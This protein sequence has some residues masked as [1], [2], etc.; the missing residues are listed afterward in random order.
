MARQVNGQLKG[1]QGKVGDVTY[2]TMN[3][4]TY[5]RKANTDQTNPQTTAQMSRR[6]R[7][8]NVVAM[9]RAGIAWSKKS[10]Q[11]KLRVQSD[12]NKFVQQNFNSSL[13]ALTREQ[14]ELGACVVAPYMVTRGSIP[15]IHLTPTP[16]GVFT[17]IVVGDASFNANSRIGEWTEAIVRNNPTILPGDQLSVIFYEQKVNVDTNI[18]YVIC[19]QYEA[20][21]DPMSGDK[22]YD[23]IPQ[24]YMS[25]AQQGTEKV[26]ATSGVLPMGGIVYVISRN[27]RRGLEVSTQSIAMTSMAVLSQYVDATQLQ[28]AMES[29]GLSAD[30]FLNP[31]QSEDAGP[32]PSSLDC[33][34]LAFGIPSRNRDYVV[35]AP[36]YWTQSEYRVRDLFADSYDIG[37]RFNDNLDALQIIIRTWGGNDYASGALTADA[38]NASNSEKVYYAS[39][40][41]QVRT[42]DEYIRKVTLSLPDS[43]TYVIDG[44]PN[45]DTD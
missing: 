14:V 45:G 39:F 33:I 44:F 20:T 43:N 26:V 22:M 12:Y 28:A 1:A 5:A 36:S 18:P 2:Y 3:G 21:L 32:T 37:V 6:V 29:Y 31:D 23:F 16:S 11:N 10:Y 15:S 42:S 13:V 40:G 17:S 25:I 24:Q 19:R 8:A 4:Q 9:Y 38:Q 35:L 30:P 41:Q 27:T 7:L 34:A